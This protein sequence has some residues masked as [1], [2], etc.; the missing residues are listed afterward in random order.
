MGK[1]TNNSS[2]NASINGFKKRVH[3]ENGKEV[4]DNQSKFMAILLSVT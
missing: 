1:E 3:K 2:T 4:K